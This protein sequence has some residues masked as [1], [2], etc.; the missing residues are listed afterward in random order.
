[1]N[2]TP[3][4]LRFDHAGGVARDRAIHRQRA[5]MEKVK[6]PDVQRATGQVDSRRSACFNSQ[7]YVLPFCQSGLRIRHDSI[8]A[9]TR[10]RTL[11]VKDAK[12]QEVLERFLLG[13]PGHEL[14]AELAGL[15]GSVVRRG[16]LAPSVNVSVEKRSKRA[17]HGDTE[18]LLPVD[19]ILCQYAPGA[20]RIAD[21]VRSRISL[22]RA[23][24]LHA[25]V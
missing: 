25:A 23:G 18:R 21:A 13:F 11:P 1:M 24:E 2:S 19:Q 9:N 16:F 3:H 7:V 14:S 4:G 12:S 6:R 17:D 5:R 15:Q 10:K 22:N 20:L 8:R